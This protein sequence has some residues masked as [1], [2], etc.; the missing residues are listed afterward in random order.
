MDL[1]NHT[2]T[3]IDAPGLLEERTLAGNQFGTADF[4]PST[5]GV[6]EFLQAFQARK[7]FPSC[8][9]LAASNLSPVEPH[10]LPRILFSHIPLYRSEGTLCGP[11]RESRNNLHQ[12]RGSRSQIATIAMLIN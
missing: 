9:H 8:S 11:L 5:G 10:P 4:R 3:L 7:L 6:A 2:V 12:G 1:G